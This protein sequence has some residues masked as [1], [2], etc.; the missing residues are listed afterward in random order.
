MS[1]T[2]ILSI[3]CFNFN[4]IVIYLLST[5]SS[6]MN[7]A[8]IVPYGPYMKSKPIIVDLVMIDAVIYTQRT[9]LLLNWLWDFDISGFT[10]S[11]ILVL[12][13][14]SSTM[15]MQYKKKYGPHKYKIHT[16]M[17]DLKQKTIA[18]NGIS[19]QIIFDEICLFN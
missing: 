5:A 18:E 14:E 3:V 12:N 2:A 1:I 16:I 7:D 15:V 9:C 6:C 4:K 19:R 11:D 13:P 10:L 8:S 17:V